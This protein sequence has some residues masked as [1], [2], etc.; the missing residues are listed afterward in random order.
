MSKYIDYIS[1]RKTGKI[2][3]ICYEIDKEG[4]NY[5]DVPITKIKEFLKII[6]KRK[7]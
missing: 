1:L 7:S 2:L 5:I 6:E 4:R 3:S